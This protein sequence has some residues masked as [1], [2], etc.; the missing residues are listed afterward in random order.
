MRVLILC[1][2]LFLQFF[3]YSQSKSNID[4]II[5]DSKGV[6]IKDVEIR[7]LN[8]GFSGQ[9]IDNKITFKNIPHGSYTILILAEGYASSVETLIIN[10]NTEV[11]RNLSSSITTLDDIV[12][13]TDKRETRFF[14]TLGSSTV[15]DAKQIRNMRIWELSNLSGIAPN[16]TLSHSG[17]NRNVTGVRGIVTT[18]YEQSVATYID[19]VAQFGLDT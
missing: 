8:H 9:P 16:L 5:K 7:F 14:K 17:D 3:A 19:G 2:T 18:S 13:N 12:V 6:N 10:G 11:V 4:F 15:L 1:V